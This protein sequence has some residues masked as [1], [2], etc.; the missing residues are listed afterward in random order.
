MCRKILGRLEKDG[1]LFARRLGRYSALG[2]GSRGLA[3]DDHR[4]LVQKAIDELLKIQIRGTENHDGSCIAFQQRFDLKLY[5]WEFEHFIEWGLEKAAR[6]GR[7]RQRDGP[8]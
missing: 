3:A 8:S 6:L 4:R 7:Q 5:M 1:I 2:P